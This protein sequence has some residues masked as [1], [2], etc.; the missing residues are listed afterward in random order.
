MLFWMSFDRFF[1][2]AR[3]KNLVTGGIAEGFDKVISLKMGRAWNCSSPPHNVVQACRERNLRN[4]NRPPR[5]NGNE[6]GS[7]TGET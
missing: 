2:L 6:A 1:L 4:I 7:G 5:N 3:T